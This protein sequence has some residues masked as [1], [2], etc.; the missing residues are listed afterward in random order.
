VLRIWECDL[1]AGRHARVIRR[2]R[3]ALAAKPGH[4]RR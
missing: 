3:V 2:L 1:I 4:V